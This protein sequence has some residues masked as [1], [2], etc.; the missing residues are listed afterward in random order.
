MVQTYITHALASQKRDWW[1]SRESFCMDSAHSRLIDH[2]AEPFSWRLWMVIGLQGCLVKRGRGGAGESV[3]S[4]CCKPH[5]SES[6][7]SLHTSLGEN[8]IKP[9]GLLWVFIWSKPW[10]DGPSDWGVSVI[11]SAHEVHEMWQ[12]SISFSE[13]NLT[14][15]VGRWSRFF[16][17]VCLNCK[18][19]IFTV[20]NCFVF[21]S[22]PLIHARFRKKWCS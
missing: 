22:C 6:H 12:Q 4:C 16:F 5:Q 18:F 7:L 2:R 11:S 15:L 13:I 19:K 8:R 10:R 17:S 14:N 1:D 3:F 20:S 9:I 21:N